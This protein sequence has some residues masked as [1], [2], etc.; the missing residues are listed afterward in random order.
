MHPNRKASV[1]RWRCLF[2]LTYVY[3]ECLH[4]RHNC[5]LELIVTETRNK[6]MLRRVNTHSLVKTCGNKRLILSQQERC[7][8]MHFKRYFR[9]YVEHLFSQNDECASFLKNIETKTTAASASLSLFFTFSI[10]LSLGYSVTK[11]FQAISQNV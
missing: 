10:S 8:T 11:T 5:F 1:T 2:F 4:G 6:Q 9:M 7:Q 3:Q